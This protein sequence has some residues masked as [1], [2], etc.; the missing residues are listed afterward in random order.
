[1]TAGTTTSRVHNIAILSVSPNNMMEMVSPATAST[2]LRSLRL[3]PI[4]A[5]TA[6]A[7]ARRAGM[8][9]ATGIRIKNGV[10]TNAAAARQRETIPWP[11]SERPGSRGVGVE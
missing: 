11:L 4:H 1:M 2:G 8:K 10:V 6:P 7:E 9:P 5:N 3:K